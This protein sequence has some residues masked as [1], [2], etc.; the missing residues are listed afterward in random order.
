MDKPKIIFVVGS[1]RSGSTLIYN[2]LCSD[3]RTNM[4]INENHLL[5]QLSSIYE[6]SLGRLVIE[7]GHFFTDKNDVKEF[8]TEYANLFIE[9]IRAKHNNASILVVKSIVLSKVVNRLSEIIPN[10]TFCLCVRDPRDIVSSMIEV[11]IKQQNKGMQS[12]YPRD[13]EMLSKF[14]LT[15]YQNFL[16]PQS[17]QLLLKTTIVK[18]EDIVQNTI[19]TLSQLEQKM[20]LDLSAYNNENDWPR[21][22]ID[23]EKRKQNGAPFLTNLWGKAISAESVGKYKQLLSSSEIKTVESVCFSIFNKFSYKVERENAF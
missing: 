12:Q 1:P 4:A 19:D 10:A 11:G 9:R 7:Q 6:F 18:Y 13:V 14:I 17:Q 8:F 2:I 20:E 22:S 23:V 3:A 15:S 21:N 16:V 5:H